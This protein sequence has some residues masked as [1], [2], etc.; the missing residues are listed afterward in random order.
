MTTSAPNPSAYLGI[1]IGVSVGIGI[2]IED[3]IVFTVLH[4]VPVNLSQYARPYAPQLARNH[5]LNVAAVIMIAVF[6][7]ATGRAVPV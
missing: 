7:L 6:A 2:G 1:G 5:G 3:N 4:L